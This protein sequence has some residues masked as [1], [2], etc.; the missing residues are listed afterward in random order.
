LIDYE[1]LYGKAAFEDYGS[2]YIDLE[3]QETS[4]PVLMSQNR[5]HIS[6]TTGVAM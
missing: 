4:E 1:K 5:R 6:L 2:I 3:G